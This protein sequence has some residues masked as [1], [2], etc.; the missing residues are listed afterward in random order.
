VFTGYTS[1]QD[2]TFEFKYQNIEKLLKYTV[3]LTLISFSA[4]PIDSND[5]YKF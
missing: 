5:Y 4:I 1:I 3:P 2:F